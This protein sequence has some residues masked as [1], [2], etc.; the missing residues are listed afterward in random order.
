VQDAAYGTLLRE[1]RRKLHTRIA[2]ETAE[3]QPELL[4]RHCTEA[5]LIEKAARLW[6][7]AGQRSLTRSALVESIEQFTRALDQIASLPGT[8]ALRREEIKLQFALITPLIYIKGFATPET[9]AAAARTRFLIEQAEA[10]GEPAE[11]PLLMFAVLN[12][13]WNASYAAFNADAMRELAAHFLAL[14]E[15]QEATVQRMMGYRLMGLSL[16]FTGEIAQGRE[17]LDRAFALYDP[18]EHRQLASRLGRDFWA[19]TLSE[20]SVALWTLGYPDSALADSER[21]LKGVR[22]FGRAAT[23]MY[24]LC[25]GSMPYMLCG[26]YAAA[27]ALY[28]ELVALTDEKGAP[29][30]KGFGMMNRGC[31]LVLTG[32][33]SDAVEMIISGIAAWRSTG[34]IFWEPAAL[35]YLARAYAELGQFHDAR[36]CIG[37]ALIAVETTK[38]RWYEAEINRMAGEVAL[39]S[40][41]ADA[42]KAQAYFERAL[43]I[44]RAQQA[45]SWELRAATSLARLWRDQR[46]RAEAYDLL[47]PVYGWF[48]EGFETLDLKEARALL[49]ELAT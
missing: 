32:N 31:L 17:H 29:V 21:M 38:E 47:A 40:P 8:P 34:A 39:F 1:P 48:T 14:A 16:L 23:L 28:D 12:V 26:N 9:K 46:R 41:Q 6:G 35:S 25:L 4:A 22:N 15:K 7:R 37:N 33:A 45:R 30:L 2:A 44:A 42:A 36:R 20:R 18:A 13:F 43:E 49:D 3:S 5:G 27:Y 19:S 11:D 24:A 10:L